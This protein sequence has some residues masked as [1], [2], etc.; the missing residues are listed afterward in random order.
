MA[1]I[2]RYDEDAG[3]RQSLGKGGG[4]HNR[5]EVVGRVRRHRG[6]PK[7][8]APFHSPAIA[9]NQAYDNGMANQFCRVMTYNIHGGLDRRN[10]PSLDLIGTTIAQCRPVLVG[11]QEVERR[12]RARAGFAD[13]PA[14]LGRQ[15]G[16]DFRFAAAINLFPAPARGKFGNAVLSGWPITSAWAERLPWRREPRVLLGTAIESPWGRL[17][18]LV[19]HFGLHQ[20]ERAR[21]VEAIL[22]KARTLPGPV[23]LVG[24]LNAGPG[25]PEL[26]PLFAEWQEV[27][28]SYGLNQ[29]TFPAS[30]ARIDFIFCPAG[31]RVL[32][33]WVIPSPASD[34][35]PLVA[36]LAWI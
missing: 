19:C 26:A 16:M 34:H 11:L 30:G 5:P 29:P 1:S 35:W 13:Q 9:R 7:R 10:Q 36:D 2:R 33:T 27:Q 25:A 32:R 22:A 21:Q 3:A 20:S 12:F 17:H 24:D 15:L 18:F 14:Q 28:T 23:I 6:R 31:W 8:A 4:R